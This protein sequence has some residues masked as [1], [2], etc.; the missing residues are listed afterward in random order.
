MEL[1]INIL[2]NSKHGLQEVNK[3]RTDTTQRLQSN[4]HNLR[5]SNSIK[6]YCKYN[7]K[8]NSRLTFKNVWL[9]KI[10]ENETRKKII[11]RVQSKVQ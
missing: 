1:F 4:K 7:R 8:F 5:E 2:E 3:K 9:L 10:K 11:S 6:R